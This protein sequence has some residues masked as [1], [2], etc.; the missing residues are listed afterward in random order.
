MIERLL[1]FSLHH[2]YL[3][4]SLTTLILCNRFYFNK[5]ILVVTLHFGY[6]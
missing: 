2:R 5:K 1:R 3:I 4:F 6:H